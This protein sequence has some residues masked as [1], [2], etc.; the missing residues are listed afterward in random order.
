M[1]EWMIEKFFPSI[2]TGISVAVIFSMFDATIG[3]AVLSAALG[4]S[5]FLLCDY[6]DVASSKL[7]RVFSAYIFAAI[8]GYLSIMFFDG[9]IAVIIAVSLTSFLM[10]MTNSSHAPAAGAS[11]GFVLANGTLIHVGSLLLSVLNLLFLTK[12]MIYLYREE[13]RLHEF[14]HEFIRNSEDL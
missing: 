5:A 10:L 9:A 4:A 11:F 13:L 3:T 12:F 14:H 1:K 7:H 6:P 8:S 2:L